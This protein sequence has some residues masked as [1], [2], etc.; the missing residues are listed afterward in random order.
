MIYRLAFPPSLY[1]G[2]NCGV[3]STTGGTICSFT[4]AQDLLTVVVNAIRIFTALAGA[5]AVAVVVLGGIYYVMSAGNPAAIKRAK[6]T[7]TNAVVGLLIA[8]LAYSIV[9]FI[10]GRF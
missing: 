5:L 8:S 10:A 6:D 2:L 9:S 3:N 7:I 4:S 1:D